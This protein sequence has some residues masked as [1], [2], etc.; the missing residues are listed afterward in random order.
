MSNNVYKVVRLVGSSSSSI[1]EAIQNAIKKAS[2]TLKNLRWF[3]VIE[4]R[5]H[6]EDGKVDHFQVTL[7]VGF[8]LEN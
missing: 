7:E 3:D 1:E 6:I 8:T 5:G 4:T 2:K